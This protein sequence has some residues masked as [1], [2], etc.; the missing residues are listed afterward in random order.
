M[1][2]KQKLT[3]YGC[4]VEFIDIALRYHQFYIPEHDLETFIEYVEEEHAKVEAAEA[5]K[6]MDKEI[7]DAS[8]L[9]LEFEDEKEI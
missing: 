3:D 1:D 6:E 8:G 9:L 2:L 4:G 5:Q 7:V